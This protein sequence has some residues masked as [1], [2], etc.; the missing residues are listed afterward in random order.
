VVV[1]LETC[2][3]DV[4]LQSFGTRHELLITERVR[5]EYEA[6][7]RPLNKAGLLG[8]IFAIVSA[9]VNDSLL[10]YFHFDASSGEISVIS[11][12]MQNNASCVIDEE[13]A[14][15]VCK[16][17]EIPLTGSVG[18]IKRMHAERLLTRREMRIV[19]ERLRKSKFYLSDELL[20]QLR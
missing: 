7:Q 19:R 13:F 15:Q 3:I 14:R 17:F 18:I 1:L 9:Q 16:L 2:S 4:A 11:Y 6:G 12:A 10:P 8:S 5:E 20:N